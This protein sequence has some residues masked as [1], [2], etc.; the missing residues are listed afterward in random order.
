MRRRAPGRSLR[1]ERVNKRFGIEDLDVVDLFTDADV[2]DGNAH[3][4]AN[5]DQS[6][7]TE[8]AD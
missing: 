7:D 1:D 5:G 8:I 6:K 3:L 4:L 2:L